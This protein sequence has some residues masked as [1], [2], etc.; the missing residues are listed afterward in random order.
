M[1]GG[2]LYIVATP[3]GNLEDITLRAIN[4]L[5]SVDAIAC[6]DT[7]H[8]RILTEKYG[9]SKPLISFYSYNQKVRAEGL[10]E[11]LKRGQRIALVSDAGTPGI[12]D[13]GYVLIRAAID[14]G[15]TVEAVPG[16][17]ALITALVVSG[18]PT[19]KFVFE[20]FLSNKSSQRKKRLSELKSEER[21]VIIYES[22]HRIIALLEDVIEVM[23]DREIVLARELTKKFEE[24]VRSSAAAALE[25]L[26]KTGPKGEFILII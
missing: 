24:I 17:S 9:I 7:R 5:K 22:P 23:G 6:E 26:K 18:K 11:N 2:K 13:P 14:N 8:T 15:I 21:T 19:A 3:I 25:K 10:V 16:A 20:G 1:T 12:S 4:T